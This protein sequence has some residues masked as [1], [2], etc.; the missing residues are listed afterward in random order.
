MPSLSKNIREIERFS[1]IVLFYVLMRRLWPPGTPCG[2]RLPAPR[3]TSLRERPGGV[4]RVV[5]GESCPAASQ[6]LQL[7]RRSRLPSMLQG[8]EWWARQGLNL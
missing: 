8:N 4:A 7:R 3:S 1:R 2:S 5:P 6:S